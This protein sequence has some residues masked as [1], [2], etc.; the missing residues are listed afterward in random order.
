[1]AENSTVA[2]P[3]AEAFFAAAGDD[4]SLDLEG[5]LGL[6]AEL[7]Q[8]IANPDV[9]SAMS[10]PRLTDAQ[11]S[12]LFRGLAK[13]TL[14]P[15]VRNLVDL[16]I[17]ND[18]LLMLPEIA[19]QFEALKNRRAGVAVAEVASAFELSEAQVKE[20]VGALEKKFGLKLIARVTVDQSL[21]GGVRVVVGDKVLDTSVQ[22]QLVRMR[23]TLA[24]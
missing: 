8:I 11:R 17:A 15:A 6:L 3:Y 16:L 18:R 24:A 23:D 19:H 21:I 13:S 22:A 12:E 7:A 14:P 10:E 9:Q 4:K 1:M 20:L 2:R 5:W